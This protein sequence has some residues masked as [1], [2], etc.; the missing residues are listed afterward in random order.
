MTT[1]WRTGERKKGTTGA[2][3]TDRQ[4][5]R[6]SR[7]LLPTRVW[8]YVA[9]PAGIQLFTFADLLSTEIGCLPRRMR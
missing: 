9:N 6:C 4:T 2:T 1:L 7:K 8:D 5:D 3:Q